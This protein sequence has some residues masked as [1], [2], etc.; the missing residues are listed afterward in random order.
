MDPQ[1]AETTHDVDVLVRGVRL[2][3]KVARTEP[4]ASFLDH[5]DRHKE[6]D[7]LL[8]L[9]TDAELE[10]IVRNRIET[11]YHP[12]CTARMA[13]KA[14]GGVVDAKLRVYGI[15]NLRVCDASV[16]PTIVS[17]HTVSPMTILPSFSCSKLFQAAACIAMAEKLA[18]IMKAEFVLK[19]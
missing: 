13:P 6:L 8:H 7:H 18:D 19:R 17:G 15:S 4:M 9:K 11:L 5:T 10:K 3:L 1:Y 12:A 2:A 14:D 16:M